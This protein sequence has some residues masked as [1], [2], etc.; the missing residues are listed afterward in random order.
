MEPGLLHLA[1][2]STDCRES[3]TVYIPFT[4]VM[5]TSMLYIRNYGVGRVDTDFSQDSHRKIPFS[6]DV[7]WLVQE[8]SICNIGKYCKGMGGIDDQTCAFL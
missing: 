1:R 5:I 8:A 7:M 4:T 3:G 6:S 2:R